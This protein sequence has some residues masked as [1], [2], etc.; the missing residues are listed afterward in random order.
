MSLTL[1]QD[2]QASRLR[3]EGQFT[4]EAHTQFRSATQEV[5]DATAAGPITLDLSGLSYLDSSALGMLL[6]LRE[7][8]E[9]KGLR[10]VLGKPSPVVMEILKIVQFGKLF[11]IQEG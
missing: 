1:H 11:E 10:V 8:A 9:S 3:L 2:L 6:L 4:F 7:K 5:L